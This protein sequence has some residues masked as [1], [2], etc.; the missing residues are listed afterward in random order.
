M[1]LGLVVLGFSGQVSAFSSTLEALRSRMSFKEV[2]LAEDGDSFVRGELSEDER[3]WMGQLPGPT[4]A[5]GTPVVGDIPTGVNN[6]PWTT[7]TYE[8]YGVD[9]HT[10]CLKV[11]DA[12]DTKRY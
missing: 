9:F 10:A 1:G 4:F 5:D 8:I 2:E 11:T 12:A 7:P 6:Q 3:D